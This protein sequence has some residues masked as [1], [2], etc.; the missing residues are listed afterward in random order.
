MLRKTA[1][2]IDMGKAERKYSVS[3]G[4]VWIEKQYKVKLPMLDDN[5]LDIFHF[6]DHL[7]RAAH[8]IYGEN[9]QQAVP[10]R[11]KMKTVALENGSLV[12]L[13][14]LKECYDGLDDADS[15][16]EIENLRNYISKRI[17]MTD[18]PDFIEK[19]YDI[20]S[21]PTESFCGCLTRRLKGSGM[22]W[23]SDNAQAIMALSSVYYS[24]L[25]DNYWK[26]QRKHA[27]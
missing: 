24:N 26:D 1:A 15:R 20:G 17:A 23:D 5:V 12:L 6:K 18:S 3:D 8:S 14:R 9:S 2:Q 16:S 25:W 10:W 11:E 21:G 7:T 19:G 13:D 4:A 22:R 27:A